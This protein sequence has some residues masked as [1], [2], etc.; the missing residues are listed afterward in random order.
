MRG[1][2]YK[3]KE[4]VDEYIRVAKEVQGAELINKLSEFLAPN[5]RLLEIGS[6]PG[7][8]WNIL[9]S[10]YDV[11]GS[12]NSR[13]FLSYLASKNPSG[14]FLELDAVTLDTDEKF[15]GLYSNKVLHHLNDEELI[16]SIKRQCEVLNENG[17][18]C[19][20]FWK[21]EGSEVFRGLYVNYHTKTA[22]KDCFEDYFETILIETYAEFEDS[23][24][25]LFI[26]KKR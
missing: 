7:T 4:S 10:N 24:S 14:M 9:K 22:L 25:L 2:Y 3:T 8:D 17:I 21:G 5:S 11:V 16:D 15:D 20:S 18:I 1:D 12:D 26:G 6:G 19:H 23:D 13:E